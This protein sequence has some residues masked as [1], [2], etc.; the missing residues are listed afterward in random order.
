[1]N[2]A[3][4]SVFFHIIGILAMVVMIWTQRAIDLSSTDP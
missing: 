2:T 1:M 3:H 4:L